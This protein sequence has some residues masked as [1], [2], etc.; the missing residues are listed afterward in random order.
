MKED[1]WTRFGYEASYVRKMAGQDF[2]DE[3]YAKIKEIDPLIEQVRG[4]M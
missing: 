3:E 1:M 4:Q 2:W